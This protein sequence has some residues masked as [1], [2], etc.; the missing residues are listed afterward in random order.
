MAKY[1]APQKQRKLC[2]SDPGSA[3]TK[4]FDVGLGDTEQSVF[5]F[6]GSI[7]YN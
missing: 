6:I 1:F 4:P 2:L 7:R 5:R 3:Y